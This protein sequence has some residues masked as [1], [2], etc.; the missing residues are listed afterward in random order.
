[1][2]SL[3]KSIFYIYTPRWRDN[4]AGIKALHLLCDAINQ[5]NGSAWLVFSNPSRNDSGVNPK[6]K[7][8]VLSRKILKEHQKLGFSAS[9][10]YTETIAGNPLRADRVI[11]WL[12]NYPGALGGPTEYSDKEWVVSYSGKISEKNKSGSDVLYLPIIDPSE[13]PNGLSKTPG[14]NLVYAGKYRAFVGQPE[15][16]QGLHYVEIYRDGVKRQPRSEVLELLGKAECL[17]LWE[18]S[19]IAV[20][21]MLLGT[22]CMFIKNPFLGELIAENELGTVGSG[23]GFSSESFENAKETLPEFQRIYMAARANFW[24]QL[25]LILNKN[26][27]Y[28]SNTDNSSIKLPNYFSSNVKHKIFLFFGIIRGQGFLTALKVLRKFISRD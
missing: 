19:S 23:Y 21:A 22:P 4:A 15:I 6:L 27:T 7:T 11:R 8:P 1:M 12:L 17:Y 24:N 14:L 28:W 3:N 16:P 13:L 20:E 18:N 2:N 10:V 25:E 9:V 5:K 26:E